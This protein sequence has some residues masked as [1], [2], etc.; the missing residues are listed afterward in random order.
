MNINVDNLIHL[1]MPWPLATELANILS[2]LNVDAIVSTP[3]TT[4]G[5]G[6]ITAPSLIGSIIAR[7]GPVA[8]FTDTTD[9]APTILAQLPEFVLGSTFSFIYKNA[10]A[11][12]ATLAGGASV[13]MSAQNI[14]GPWSEGEYYATWGG[15]SAAPT[16]VITHILTTAIS[17]SPSIANPSAVTLATVSNG[18]ILASNFLAGGTA[19]TGSQ[20]ATPFTDTTDNATA[21]IAANPGLLGKIGTSIRYEYANLT[22]A[23]ATLAGGT[24]VTVSQ[25]GG[26]LASTAVIPAGMTA[27]FNL[28][29]TAAG[30]LTL[31]CIALSNNDASVLTLAGSTSGQASIQPSAVAGNTTLTLPP[32]TGTA[33]S[34]SGANLNIAD[35][36]RTTTAQ[37]ANTNVVPA[38][39]TGLSGAVVVGTYKF[40]AYLPSTVAS[41]TGGIAYQFLLATAVLG[42]ID[43]TAHG[44]T[45][46]AVAVQHTTTTTSATVLFTQ[47][48]VVLSVL[49]EGTFTVTTAG[50]F[51]L[52]MCQSASNASNS[53]ALVGG[54]ME[55]TRIA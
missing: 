54:Y 38:Q 33:A 40:K 28:T 20:S 42:V 43:C 26:A 23:V 6:I 1:G 32:V 41:G 21:I 49:L 44:F 35:I 25:P 14:V 17:L 12:S 30:T 13:T 46:A 5:N 51:G 48:A 18:T 36:Y 9:D 34:T 45:A 55:L 11:F 15:T 27:G 22:N 24:G 10:T 29:Y 2:A 37:T 16:L 3:I 8:A 19:R 31:V 47:A 53:V 39:I 7:T 52:T 50:T 4:V